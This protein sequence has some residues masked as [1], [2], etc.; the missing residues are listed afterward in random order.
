[1]DPKKTALDTEEM[2]VIRKNFLPEELFPLMEQ[3][4]NSKECIAVQA[5][6]KHPRNCLFVVIWRWKRFYQ[7]R[8]SAWVAFWLLIF[9]L[10]AGSNIA[11]DQTRPT[12]GYREVTSI[13]KC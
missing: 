3:D 6:E 5:D 11:H 2:K 10:G 13:Q 8:E 4:Q 12:K 7:R 1:M 9:W